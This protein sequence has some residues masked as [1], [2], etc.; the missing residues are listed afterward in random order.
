[1][2]G[3]VAYIYDIDDRFY[4]RLNDEMV[5]ALAVTRECDKQELRKLV[6]KHFEKTQSERARSLLADWDTSL[7][8]FVR[9]IA[10]ERAALEA[11]ETEHEAAS[12]R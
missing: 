10:K 6:E 11:A 12:S 1:M 9:V 8:K 2:S 5:V 4:S 7:R 3:G